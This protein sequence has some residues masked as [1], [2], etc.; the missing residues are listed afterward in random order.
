MALDD[1]LRRHGFSQH[2][3]QTWT[4]ENEPERDLGQWFVSPPFYDDVLGRVGTGPIRPTSHVVF[5]SPGAGKT[6]LRKMVER[7]LLAS[8]PAYLIIRYTNFSRVLKA[9]GRPPAHRHVDEI[10][11]LGTIGLLA[12]WLQWPDRYDKLN[13]QERAELAGLVLEYYESLP[14]DAK[15]SYTSTLSP[16]AGRALTLLKGSYRT[17]VEGYNGVISVLNKEKIEPT[18][19][20]TPTEG[21]ESADPVSRLERFWYLAKALGLEGV[22]VLVDSVDEHPLANSGLAIFEAMAELLLNLRILEFREGDKQVICFK[23][24]LTRPAEVL[25]LMEQAYFRKDRVAIRTIEWTRRDLDFALQKRL[26]HYSNNHVLSFDDMCDSALKGT[27]DKLLDAAQ[28]RPR[29]LFRTAYEVFAVFQRTAAP[30]LSKIDRDSVT[31][32]LALGG[33]A[34]FTPPGAAP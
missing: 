19:W 25:P 5:G 9:P 17:I 26:A 14:L 34:V 30:G 13:A 32:G 6:A 23:V 27:H 16:Y 21:S 7:D 24:F 22:W 2:P 20:A 28:L 3:F 31:E 15:H 33:R 1:L 12:Y 8:V 29:V 10:L 4:A 18:K 11:R